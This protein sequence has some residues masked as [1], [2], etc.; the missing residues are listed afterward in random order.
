MERDLSTL[1][2]PPNARAVSAT[3]A[4]QKATAQ[5][6]SPACPVTTAAPAIAT[7]GRKRLTLKHQ[8]HP[9]PA[10]GASSSATA[11]HGR[12]REER[13]RSK[14]RPRQPSSSAQGS[15]GNKSDTGPPRMYG[16]S[17]GLVSVPMK[18]ETVS[19]FIWM[20]NTAEC[21]GGH[22]ALHGHV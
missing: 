18:K 15:T 16:T 13:T 6:P 21:S 4:K 8:H 19:S 17:G 2:V 3:P 14:H 7:P 5:T 1:A 11:G 22:G 10:A 20:P 12:S 9:P